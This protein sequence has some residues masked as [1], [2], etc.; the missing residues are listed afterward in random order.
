MDDMKTTAPAPAP[1]TKSAASSAMTKN[2]L[3]GLGAGILVVLVLGA[4][5]LALGVYKFGWSGGSTTSLLRVFPYPAAT[6]NGKAIAYADFLD[7]TATLRHF[8]E[9]QTATSA[10]PFPVPSEEEI[11]ENVLQRLIMNE[12]L[13]QAAERYGITV[14]EEE[15]E[16]EFQ[17]LAAASGGVAVV[18][19]DLST[20]YGWGPAQ[21]KQ[22]VLRPFLQ[23]TKLDEALRLDMELNG[24]AEAVATAV[25]ERAQS[26]E[27]FAEL[28]KEFSA[29]PSTGPLGGELGWFER[30]VMVPEFE[31]AAFALEPG[32]VSGVVQSPFGYHVILVHEREMDGEEVARVRAAHILLGF[33][34]SEEY[35]GRQLET[36]S[37]KRYVGS[38]TSV[39]VTE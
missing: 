19:E 8:Y 15:I 16:A 29:D 1:E 18:E 27:D 6:V 9:A 22:K 21:F 34:G 36:A 5:I 24:E 31:V 32:S 2:M 35:L 38:E 13:D 12:L 7:D 28:A 26:G 30:G 11:K 20:V 3:M 39:E 33:I 23:Q 4:G 25:A 14:T 10:E 17:N 37:I